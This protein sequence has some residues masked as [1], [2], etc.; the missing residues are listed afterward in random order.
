[1]NKRWQHIT[2]GLAFVF[3]GL[4]VYSNIHQQN[5]NDR[6]KLPSK[7]EDSRQ[8]QRWITNLRNKDLFF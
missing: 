7:V 1:M 8:F 2:F 6:S 5:A 4:G 3:I